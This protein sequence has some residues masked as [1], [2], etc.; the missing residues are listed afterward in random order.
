MVV[1][2]VNID[3]ITIKSTSYK[4]EVAEDDKKEENKEE[5]VVIENCELSFSDYSTLKTDIKTELDNG[6]KPVEMANEFLMEK[7]CI[8]T[9]QVLD[10]LAIFNLDGT[11]LKFAKMAYRFCS[12][13]QKYHMAVGKMAYTKNKQAL[14]EF[15]E[16]QQ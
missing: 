3:A 16:Q 4:D 13:K 14:E 2:K 6:G 7:G 8:S 5:K 1:S 12:D 11:R 15:L 9:A 10:Y